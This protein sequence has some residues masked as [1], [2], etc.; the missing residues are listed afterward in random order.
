[1]TPS[2]SKVLKDQQALEQPPRL[3]KTTTLC[4]P[5]MENDHGVPGLGGD[6]LFGERR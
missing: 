3:T 5:V 2:G 1:M 6:S 4:N